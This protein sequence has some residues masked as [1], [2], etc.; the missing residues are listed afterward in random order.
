MI[1]IFRFLKPFR[2]LIALVLA[3]AFLQSL[4]NLYL[5]TLMADIVDNGIVTGDTNYILRVGGVMLLVTLGGTLCAVVGAFFAARVAVGFGRIVR[6]KL[7][8]HVEDFSLHEF[9]TVS[10]AS[11]ITR[12]TND[13]TQVQ[14][15]LVIMLTMMVTA[16]MMAIGG[17]ILALGQ[18]ATL[19]WILV[20]AVPRAG[21]GD[22]RSDDEPRFRSSSH[23]DK[24]DRLN[25]M[26]D[27]GLTGVRVIRAF[28]RNAH[29]EQRFDVANWR[30]DRR[31]RSPST[32]S[33]PLSGRS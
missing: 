22:P 6:R 26:L 8:T 27:E 25:L 33:S 31:S 7:F 1:R 16:P 17:V 15:V 2:A 24:L 20:V 23:A 19:A 14:Q 28:D 21:A 32:G 10:T 29:E 5:P 12:T 3:L 4:A 11:L 9:D 18:D 13:T 30:P